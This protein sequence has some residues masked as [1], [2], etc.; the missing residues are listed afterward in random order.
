MMRS[1]TRTLRILTA[2]VFSGLSAGLLAAA[3]CRD[4]MSNCRIAALEAFSPETVAWT[5][6]LHWINWLPGVVF[7][8]FFALA[9]LQWAPFYARRASLFSLVSGLIYVAAGLLFSIL[10]DIAGADEVALVVWIWPAGLCAGL[11]GGLL[12]AIAANRFLQPVD[13]ALGLWTGTPLPAAVGA[14][15]GVV[16]VLICSYGE[17]H[18]FVAFPAAFVIWQVGVGLALQPRVASQY[19]SRV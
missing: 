6:W 1:R 11:L 14:L 5:L 8:L 17:Q 9:A 16:F 4:A 12:L 10:L 7:G 3:Q 13:A 18:I 15:L 19:A 2:C